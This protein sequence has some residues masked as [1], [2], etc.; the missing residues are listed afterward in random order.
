MDPRDSHK[1]DVEMVKKGDVIR[2]K[3][4]H[5]EGGAF[6]ETSAEV[7]ELHDK[8]CVMRRCGYRFCAFYCDLESGNAIV[9]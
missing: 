4:Q 6:F 1:G 7:V 3:A 5:P 9:V 8:F 2:I